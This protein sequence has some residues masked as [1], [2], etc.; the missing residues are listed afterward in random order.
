MHLCIYLSVECIKAARS[1]A[2]DSSI[3][4]YIYAYTYVYFINIYIYTCIYIYS[5]AS[6]LMPPTL[7]SPS[8]HLRIRFESTAGRYC[9]FCIL[10]RIA[11][12]PCFW[13]SHRAVHSI[14]AAKITGF[15]VSTTEFV[16]SE[17]QRERERGRE[18]EGEE[19]TRAFRLL[20]IAIVFLP[21]SR[22]Q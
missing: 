11:Q 10:L 7:S 19:T 8:A 5:N 15:R 17:R 3:Y 21:T 2:E 22:N 12:G 13:T 18:R 14:C 9:L 1:A 4:I 20:P 16:E 6:R